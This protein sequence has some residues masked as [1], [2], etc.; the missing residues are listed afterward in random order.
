MNSNRLDLNKHRN[1]CILLY[2]QN[3]FLLISLHYLQYV[4]TYITIETI[5]AEYQRCI[6]IVALSTAVLAF[7]T[8]I[9][10]P[11]YFCY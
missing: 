1:H 5:F 9:L 2:F 8:V 11:P 6:Y 7:L 3:T 4:S 10:L